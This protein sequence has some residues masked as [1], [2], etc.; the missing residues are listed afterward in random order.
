M[1]RKSLCAKYRKRSR[2]KR[3]AQIMALIMKGNIES[4]VFSVLLHLKI[5]AT[6][7]SSQRHDMCN[8]IWLLK[9]QELTTLPLARSEAPLESGCIYRKMVS[10]LIYICKYSQINQKTSVGKKYFRRFILDMVQIIAPAMRVKS[11]RETS[12][13]CSEQEV[14]V[15]PS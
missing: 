14:P 15:L 2:I 10:F 4:L 6:G 9:I 1:L 13:R 11:M 3:W 5:K 8:T 12:L 7:S